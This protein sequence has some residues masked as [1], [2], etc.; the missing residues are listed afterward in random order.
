M[1]YTEHDITSYEKTELAEKTIKHITIHK[2][3]IYNKKVHNTEA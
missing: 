2:H 3:K 1:V